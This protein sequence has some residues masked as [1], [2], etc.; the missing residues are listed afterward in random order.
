MNTDYTIVPSS[1]R[2]VKPMSARMRAA[3]S[4]A[5]Q[6]FGLVPREALHRAFMSSYY[7]RTA[8]KDDR[9]VA[10][11]GVAAPIIGDTAAIWLVLAQDMGIPPL[12]IVRKARE[13]LERVAETYPRV[14]M[15]VLPDDEDSVAFALFLGFRPTDGE[16]FGEGDE[17]MTNP[18]FRIPIGDSY[19][20][21][22]GYAPTMVN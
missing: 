1:I 20:V 19:I 12:P 15:T 11:W 5:V 21:Q 3:G 22:M 16:V 2:H 18:R 17:G 7:C 8:L 13:E 14:M 4:I 10:M 6:A 9:P